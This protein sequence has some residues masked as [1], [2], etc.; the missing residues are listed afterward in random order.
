MLIS[1][2]LFGQ[3]EIKFPPTRMVYQ[4]NTS[5]NATLF[6]TGTYLSN[7]GKIQARLKT[8][9]GEPGVAVSWTDIVG[10]VSGNVFSGSL[11]A[12]GGRY[13]L[14]VR[15]L[16]NGQQVGSSVTV[17]KVGVLSITDS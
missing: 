3:I 1:I 12:S 16:K 7:I 2:S 9:A 8:R 10:A 4:R 5:G 6:I 14:E 15:G 17:E 13:D 11:S